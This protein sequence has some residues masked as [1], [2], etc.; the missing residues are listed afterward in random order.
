MKRGVFLSEGGSEFFTVF[1]GQQ[2]KA[3]AR[4]VNFGRETVSNLHVAVKFLDAKGAPR[5][6]V[7]DRVVALAPGEAK[8]V[9]QAGLSRNAG[10][11]GVSASL[12]L[13]GALIDGLHH[14][15]GVWEPKA[16]PQYI[17][18]RDGGFWWRG[19]PWKAHGVNY[20]PSSGIGLAND[21]LLRDTGW[22]A[23]PTIPR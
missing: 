22:D 7:L 8:A 12:T 21:Q 2:F 5:R 4:V 18:A 1:A 17:E 14:E 23:G 19:K 11:A 3:G 20:M 6:E 16:K 10:E 13:D 9:E 15:L